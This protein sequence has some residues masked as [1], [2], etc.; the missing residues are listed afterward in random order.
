MSQCLTFIFDVY[1][2]SSEI[3][4]NVLDNYFKQPLKIKL[5]KL[6]KEL[7]VYIQPTQMLCHHTRILNNTSTLDLFREVNCVLVYKLS[8]VK[9]SLT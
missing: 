1:K 8:G 4:L 5:L 6:L 2:N 7:F 9:C 3:S